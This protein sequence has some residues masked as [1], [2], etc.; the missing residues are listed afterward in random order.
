M[1]HYSCIFRFHA[2]A[3]GYYKK[4]V[5]HCLVIVPDD[6]GN[7]EIMAAFNKRFDELFPVKFYKP[8]RKILHTDPLNPDLAIFLDDVYW[9]PA[10][11]NP[12]PEQRIAY[13]DNML[14]W[15]PAG[16]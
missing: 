9:V 16:A 8:W 13:Y 10:L 2:S 4:R 14:K 15:H 11:E 12:T 6:A 5:S 3:D 1:K 7:D